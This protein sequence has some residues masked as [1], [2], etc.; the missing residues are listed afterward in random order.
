M[1][2]EPGSS[3]PAADSCF[4]SL[5]YVTVLGLGAVC[6]VLARPGP[7]PAACLAKVWEE[8]VASGE[9]KA[10]PPSRQWEQPWHT[11]GPRAGCQR[12]P[13]PWGRGLAGHLWGWVGVST[14][15]GLPVQ[16]I[17]RLTPAPT[18]PSVPQALLTQGLALPS[19]ASVTRHT[20]PYLTPCYSPRLPQQPPAVL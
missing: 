1:A 17:S 20:A 16:S 12:G 6:E 2:P 5:A 11:P 3:L 14:G 19:T 15:L 13:G 8:A 7:T 4:T 10:R 9:L 18:T